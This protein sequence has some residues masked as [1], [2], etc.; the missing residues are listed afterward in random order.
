M[1]AKDFHN[2]GRCVGIPSL[3]LP[4]QHG[5][6][7]EYPAQSRNDITNQLSSMKRKFANYK[8]Y[9][10]AT[11]DEVLSPEDRQGALRL[12]AT[13]L[14]SCFLR[15]DG[16]GKFT[17]LPLPNEAQTSVVNGMV[18]DDFDGDGNLDVLINGNDFG[19][20][21]GI[22]RYDAMN[23]LLLKGDGAGGFTP[24]SMLQ[25]GICIPGNGKAMVK[26]RGADGSYLVAASQ[27]KNVLKL[28]QL[29][30]QAKSV[31]LQPDDISATIR[32]PN[33]KTQKEKFYYGNSFLS[34]SARFLQVDSGMTSVT[35][36]DS[37][38]KTR[39]LRF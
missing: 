6:K 15:N 12:K 7:R 13:M 18:V 1:T 4:D 2:N 5:V 26:L 20:S 37:K 36:T 34:Q 9:A 32:F 30:R 38:G 27:N 25:S 11:M 31:P 8:S 23:G 22:G 28:Y 39:L 10:T 33:G 29:N 24:L 3:F 14:Q 35:I 21:I 17:L 19:T 16:G